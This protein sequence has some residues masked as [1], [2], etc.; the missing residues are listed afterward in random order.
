[1]VALAF[2]AK[3]TYRPAVAAHVALSGLRAR[4]RRVGLAG[5]HSFTRATEKNAR[6][7]GWG[8]VQITQAAVALLGF[9]RAHNSKTAA[10]RV[11]KYPQ[12]RRYFV[13]SMI[14]N[15]GSWLQ[16]TAQTLLAYRFTH[17]ISSVG[18]VTCAQFLP[19]LM[20]GPWAGI[21]ADR[22]R[23]RRTL[24]STQII[25][26]IITAVMAVLQ[27]LQIFSEAYLF[28]PLSQLD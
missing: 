1:M 5:G 24:I 7:I 10:W 4:L 16:V 26:A 19:P 17:S 9:G 3:A 22:F 23:V 12:F 20:F 8:T 2:G 6:A 28:I 25:S 13:G 21:V 15:L 11:L 18:F 14:S 27:L